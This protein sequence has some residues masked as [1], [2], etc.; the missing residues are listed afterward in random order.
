MAKGKKPERIED[1]LFKFGRQIPVPKS[2]L[3]VSKPKPSKKDDKK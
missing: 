3:K 2:E 1:S